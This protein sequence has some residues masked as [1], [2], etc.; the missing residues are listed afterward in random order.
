MP[1]PDGNRMRR[2]RLGSCAKVRVADNPAHRSADRGYPQGSARSPA[3]CEDEIPSH[4]DDLGAEYR[5][6]DHAETRSRRH[7]KGHN[8]GWSSDAADVRRP[9]LRPTRA[10]MA[11]DAR[12]TGCHQWLHLDNPLG[13]AHATCSLGRRCA[14]WMY[15][16]SDRA[17][18]SPMPGTQYPSRNR[19]SRDGSYRNR[20]A[21]VRT[22]YCRHRRD[23]MPIAPGSRGPV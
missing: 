19:G 10:A 3:R 23:S 4:P 8:L 17:H 18:P 15:H 7:R 21:P 22:S 13:R 5:A 14:R 6:R 16:A 9:S 2:L 12:A 11:A 1:D 20:L